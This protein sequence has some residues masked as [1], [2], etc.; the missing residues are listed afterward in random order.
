M[1]VI[2]PH[3]KFSC[4]QPGKSEGRN[5]SPEGN[6]KP[7]SRRRLLP[8]M[9]R[10]RASAFGLLSAFGLRV[11]AFSLCTLLALLPLAAQAAPAARPNVVIILADDQ[12]WGDLSINGNTNLS[13]PKI[14]S[15]A[16]DGALLRTLLRLPGLLAHA[17]RVP[18]RPLPSARR[19]AR[20]LDRRRAAEPRR[21]DHRATP[22]RPPATPRAPSANGTTAPSIPIIPTPAAST[23]T[24]A[25]PPAT[26]A[27]TST[28]RWSTTAS[29][30]GA[31]A[32][33]PTT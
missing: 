14:D 24:T 3:L 23:N 12:G 1:T 19:R 10:P 17:R 21:E 9:Q 22:S 15:L 13:T 5:P 8:D 30:S 11:S 20:R 29:W 28:R 32:S 6:P 7:E 26:G 27:T 4:R 16:K 25:S 18:H 31:R 33:S 2:K